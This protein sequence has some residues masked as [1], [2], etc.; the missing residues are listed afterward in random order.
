MNSNSLDSVG[1]VLSAAVMVLAVTGAVVSGGNNVA[2]IFAGAIL[3]LIVSEK[4]RKKFVTATLF[5]ISDSEGNIRGL[6]GFA[7]MGV[8]IGVRAWNTGAS[9]FATVYSQLWQTDQQVSFTFEG[10]KAISG[11]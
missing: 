1:F 5:R 8:Q 10:A 11:G 7:G 2:L 4:R 6:I 9:G 3:L